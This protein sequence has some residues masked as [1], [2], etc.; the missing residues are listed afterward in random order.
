MVD[1]DQHCRV[2]DVGDPFCGG[3]E[4]P[5][6]V[7][8]ESRKQPLGFEEDLGSGLVR[9]GSIEIDVGESPRESSALGDPLDDGGPRSFA[10]FGLQSPA[11]P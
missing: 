9:R 7:G 3:P 4:G 10:I 11:Q 6:S 8:G 1:R 2:I 5:K